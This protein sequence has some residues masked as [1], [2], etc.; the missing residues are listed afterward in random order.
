MI[1]YTGIYLYMPLMHLI[2]H[3]FCRFFSD[4]AYLVGIYCYMLFQSEENHEEQALHLVIC[5]YNLTLFS[6][7]S[8]NHKKKKPSNHLKTDMDGFIRQMIN[9]PSPSRFRGINS[10]KN[11]NKHKLT[12]FYTLPGSTVNHQ[13]ASHGT[14]LQKKVTCSFAV[15]SMNIR[16]KN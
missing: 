5:R 9:F 3:A 13:N 8:I 4:P 14:I 12:R 15:S 11:Q 16:C 7:P 6:I 2:L 1:L 10:K